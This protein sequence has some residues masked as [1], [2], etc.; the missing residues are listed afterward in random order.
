M[1]SWFAG[2]LSIDLTENTTVDTSLRGGADGLIRVARVS[3]HFEPRYSENSPL[4][5][6]AGYHHNYPTFYT[7]S[8][9]YSLTSVRLESCRFLSIDHMPRTRTISTHLRFSVIAGQVKKKKKIL[10]CCNTHGCAGSSCL[11]S[12]QRGKTQPDGQTI[13]APW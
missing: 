8:S 4:L 6:A 3:E 12:P 9:P 1:S 7:M 5:K 13:P 2:R 10:T 11:S